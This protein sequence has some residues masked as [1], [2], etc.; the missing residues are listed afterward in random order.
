MSDFYL[1]YIFKLPVS[2]EV[3][4]NNIYPSAKLQCNR[5][6][7]T[8]VISINMWTV[9]CSG[10]S[11]LRAQRSLTV[12][13]CSLT[14]QNLIYPVPKI[15]T[16]GRVKNISL[17]ESFCFTALQVKLCKVARRYNFQ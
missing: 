13:H 9:P 5:T 17:L 14:T 4:V 10:H 2:A 11:A 8:E 1:P 3:D 16:T 15:T 12:A 7:D 6:V